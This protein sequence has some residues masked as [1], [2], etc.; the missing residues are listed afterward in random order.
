MDTISLH[1]PQTLPNDRSVSTVA[2]KPLPFYIYAVVFAS[3]SITVGLIW[4]I[5]WHISIGRD[6]LFSPPHL[7]TYLG[8]VTSGLFSGYYVLRL[9]FGGRKEERQSSIKF[10]KVFYGSLGALFCIWGAFTMI[11][12]APFDDWWHNTFGLDVQIL[13]PPH[14]VLLL[15]MI[16]I[17]FGAMVSVIALQN[18]LSTGANYSPKALAWCFMLSSG[19]LLVMLFTIASEYLT[20][21]DMHE[22]QFFQVGGIIFPLFLVAIS[23]ASKSK[24]GA[25]QMALVYMGLM[26]AMVW[27]LPLFPAEPKLGPV[28]N[29]I[30]HYQAFHFPLLLVFP[31]LIIDWLNHRI[32]VSGFGKGLLKTLALGAAFTVVF[33]VVQ[34]YFGDFLTTEMAKSWVFGTTSWYFGNDPNYEFRYSFHPNN[35]ATGARLW[36]GMAWALLWSVVSAGIGLIWGRWM[37]SVK[38]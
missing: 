17:Q 12:S 36:Q 29:H 22:P 2:S 5:A 23:K 30:T 38:R 15:G 28:A 1:A 31:A 4:D 9:T 32:Q 16:T 19:F 8:A 24:W 10:W 37:T 14:T 7:A 27:I 33:F 35:I 18:R 3:F 13:S 26:A 6:G 21:H 20:R 25:T 11:T 34:W